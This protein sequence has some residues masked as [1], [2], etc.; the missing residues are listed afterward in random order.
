MP[1]VMLFSLAYC[2]KYYWSS[3]N[4]EFFLLSSSGHMNKKSKHR[5]GSAAGLFY[6]HGCFHS[7][8]KVTPSG[9]ETSSKDKDAEE[10]GSS[11]ELRGGICTAPHPGVDIQAY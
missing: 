2:A 7:D 5:C 11:T 6:V 10:S 9:T 8:I 3:N 1:K 4:I